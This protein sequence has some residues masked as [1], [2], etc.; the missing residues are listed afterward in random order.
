ME[1]LTVLPLFPQYSSAATGSAVEYC[2]KQ[3]KSHWNIPATRFLGPFY[4]QPQFI[5]ALAQQHRQTL[6]GFNADYVLFSYHGLPERHMTKSEGATDPIVIAGVYV[7]CLA[8]I[9][10]FVIAPSFA[11]IARLRAPWA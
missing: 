7:L 1:H 6:E 8:P 9:I 11:T 5:D 2:M 3:L 10:A 4:D